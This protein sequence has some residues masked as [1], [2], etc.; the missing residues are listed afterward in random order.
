MNGRPALRKFGDRPAKEDGQK[1]MSTRTAVSCT[2]SASVNHDAR[3]ENPSILSLATS[4]RGPQRPLK[5]HHRHGPRGLAAR[6]KAEADAMVAKAMAAS[7]II[8]DAPE[9]SARTFPPTAPPPPPAQP[10]AVDDKAMGAGLP[11]SYRVRWVIG[12]LLAV[13]LGIAVYNYW[14][15]SS[16][17]YGTRGAYGNAATR[18]YEYYEQPQTP[19]PPAPPPPPLAIG[20]HQF[21]LPLGKNPR[22]PSEPLAIGVHQFELPQGGRGRGTRHTR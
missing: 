21:E 20:V 16:G 15:S 11:P 3:V 18:Y 5:S 8:A 19:P 1:V 6:R 22:D 7:A 13:L 2:A 10:T 4:K 9:D 12:A 14:S 17:A